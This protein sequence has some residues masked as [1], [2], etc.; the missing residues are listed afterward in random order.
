MKAFIGILVGILLLFATLF[1]LQYLGI[2]NYKFFAPK[3]E[4]ARREVFENTQSYVQ[5]KRQ[6]LTKY[7]TEWMK[8]D[9]VGQEV[10]KT[11]VLQEF[12]NFDVEKLS[13]SQKDWLGMMTDYEYFET[14]VDH[15]KVEST[16]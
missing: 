12:A 2:M 1:G 15:I 7:Y 4:N 10:I 13:Q 14:D 8:A 11:L 16:D 5:A 3:K 6:A 9:S